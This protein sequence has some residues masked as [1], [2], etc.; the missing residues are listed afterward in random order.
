[1]AQS[2]DHNKA[3]DELSQSFKERKLSI[4]SSGIRAFTLENKE[5]STIL[6]LKRLKEWLQSQ[7]TE[8][9]T[10][11]QLRK[12][13]ES[14]ITT[15]VSHRIVELQKELL[16]VTSSKSLKDLVLERMQCSDA[17]LNILF[18][19][20]TPSSEVKHRQKYLD[21]VEQQNKLVTEILGHQKAIQRTQKEL[22]TVR[23]E[24]MEVKRDNRE[25][26]SMYQRIKS[27]NEKKR[28][29]NSR[30]KEE[31]S[32]QKELDN[33]S[34]KII[35]AQHVLQALIIGSGVNW[36]KD[37]QLQQLLLSLGESL[38]FSQ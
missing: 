9:E 14:E 16:N 21:L 23:Q 30:Q 25:L 36:A 35:I 38:D 12:T 3:F 4:S 26:M 19:R 18:P 32:I 5:G 1:M 27:E 33:I 20:E 34:S 10:V 2:T 24:A 28:M 17:L 15:D 8:L 37:K 13:R 7:T 22:D 11:L 6:E 29:K 31:E